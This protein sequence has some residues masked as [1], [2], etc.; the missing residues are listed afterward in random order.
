VEKCRYQVRTASLDVAD[1]D[2]AY[3]GGTGVEAFGRLNVVVNNAG[4]GEVAPFEQLSS[5]R[6]KAVVNTNS[7]G[8]VDVTRAALTLLLLVADPDVHSEDEVPDAS[9]PK[10]DIDDR[11]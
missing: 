8:V 9:L 10:R 1:E 3:R 7:Y 4:Y 11:A 6:F 2:A 5:E